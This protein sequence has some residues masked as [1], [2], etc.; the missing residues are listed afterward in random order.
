MI[1]LK[2]STENKF[3][4]YSGSESNEITTSI[5]FDVLDA[6]KQIGDGCVNIA[7]PGMI[8]ANSLVLTMNLRDVNV[9]PEEIF[10]KL[11]EL[12]KNEGGVL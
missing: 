11:S 2:K 8:G 3:I 1:T 6:E 12:F 9:T 5:N 7:N 4:C 10:M